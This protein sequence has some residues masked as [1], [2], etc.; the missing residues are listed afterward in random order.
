MRLWRAGSPVRWPV[1]MKFA[2]AVGA[3]VVC[4]L[5]VST[6]AA[7]GLAQLRSDIERLTSEDLVGIRVIGDLAAGLNVVEEAALAEQAAAGPGQATG[8]TTLDRV[9]LPRLRDQLTTARERFGG[10][11]SASERLSR[12][13]KDLDDYLE[14]RS[15]APGA[16]GPADQAAVIARVTAAFDR[17]TTD[18][19]SG[20]EDLDRQPELALTLDRVDLRDVAANRTQSPVVVEL[21][22]RGL[23]PR[24]TADHGNRTR[25]AVQLRRV[26]RRGRPGGR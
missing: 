26:V 1:G 17:M 2:G 3:V 6:V 19:V 18:V 25:R 14:L 15:A 7:M 13:S 12:V 5:S 24:G 20:L 8:T 4:V 10:N 21:S 9:L 23:E 11:A 22:G 16:P